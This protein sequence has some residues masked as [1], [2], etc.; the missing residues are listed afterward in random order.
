MNFSIIIPTLNEYENIEA[1][2][3]EIRANIFSSDY[4]YEIVFVD[5]NS[6]DGTFDQI[7]KFSK[8][9]NNVRGI[10]RIG[11]KGLASAVCEGALSCSSEYIIVMDADLQ[12]DTENI[13]KIIEFLNRNFDL[14]IASRNMSRLHETFDF[15]RKTLSKVGNKIFNMLISRNLE[16]PLSGFFGVK[17]EIMTQAIIKMPNSIKGFKILF[18]ILYYA[19][20]SI[21]IKEI[22]SELRKRKG[23]LSKL[24][25]NILVDTLEVLLDKTIG[26]ILPYKFVLFIFSGLLGAF[27]HILT[28]FIFYKKL[29]FQFN[30]SYLVAMY[31]A[32]TINFL[33]NNFITYRDVRLKKYNLLKGLL[34]FYVVCSIG[35]FFNILVANNLFQTGVLWWLTAICG[36]IIGAVWNYSV[37]SFFTWKIK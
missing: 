31:L 9:F 12:H 29:G 4:N 13:P 20:S 34:G 5:D 30:S 19:N 37:S 21:K 26:K 24:N 15:P 6:I 18:E 10:L 33:I 16:D 23:G 17:R 1:L 35:S 7:I 14:V 11:R 25:Y 28:L 27:F 2:I 8:K 32:M 36:G 22:R 3:K